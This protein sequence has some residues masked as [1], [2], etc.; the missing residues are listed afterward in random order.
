MFNA[1]V[2]STEPFIPNKAQV[3]FEWGKH[4]RILFNWASVTQNPIGNYPVLTNETHRLPVDSQYCIHEK[5]NLTFYDILNT[6]VR[7]LLGT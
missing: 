6:C 2:N 3:D 7:I 5:K 1:L 4:M